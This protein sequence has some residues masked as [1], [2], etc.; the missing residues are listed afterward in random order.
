MSV[1][2]ILLFVAVLTACAGSDG[3]GRCEQV[4][5]REAQLGE[6]IVRRQQESQSGSLGAATD[7]KEWWVVLEAQRSADRARQQALSATS[8]PSRSWRYWQSRIPPAS[9]LLSEPRS[10]PPIGGGRPPG[11][12]KGSRAADTT[13]QRALS[14]GP[15]NWF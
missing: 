12:A 1:Q 6:E 15:S 2:R 13:R 8:A 4:H 11:T 5:A 9:I 7:S 3:A 10:K 14:G